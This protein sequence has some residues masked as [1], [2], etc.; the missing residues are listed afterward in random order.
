ML[1]AALLSYTPAPLEWLTLRVSL[2]IAQD[3]LEELEQHLEEWVTRGRPRLGPPELAFISLGRVDVRIAA[4]KPQEA[5]GLLRA[6][7]PS[8]RGAWLSSILIDESDI[9][10]LEGSPR[11]AVRLATQALREATHNFGSNI[12]RIAQLQLARSY[13][14]AGELTQATA[15]LDKVRTDAEREGLKGLELDV[16]LA[17]WEQS[18]PDPSRRQ[19]EL[20]Q[21]E[22]D[23]TRAGYLA[24]ARQAREAAAR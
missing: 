6:I 22:A 24:L 12:G 9:A 7:P 1:D 20:K 10:R 4:K 8:E 5:A 15:L 14:A 11:S 16:R 13:R 21:L 23:A 18:P 19:Q 17:T 3:R 2:Y